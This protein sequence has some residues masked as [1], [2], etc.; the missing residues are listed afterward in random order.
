MVSPQHNW[1]SAAVPLSS[2]SIKLM[3]N[4]IALMY[5]GFISN[6]NSYEMPPMAPVNFKVG[7]K[8]LLSLEEKEAQHCSSVRI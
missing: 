6:K 5:I 8:E 4:L 2:H 1:N 3:F 7:A